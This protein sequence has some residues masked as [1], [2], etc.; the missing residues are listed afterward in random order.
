M[1]LS[2]NLEIS[3]PIESAT[4]LAGES[5]DSVVV[6]HC[7]DKAFIDSLQVLQFL[8][9]CQA[10]AELSFYSSE[11]F[12]DD[13]N[14]FDPVEGY[15][16]CMKRQTALQENNGSKAEK[17][18]SCKMLLEKKEKLKF[19]FQ[20]VYFE[21]PEQYFI[22][23]GVVVGAMVMATIT[24]TV[25]DCFRQ[26]KRNV[27]TI[28]KGTYTSYVLITNKNTFLSVDTFSTAVLIADPVN[29]EEGTSNLQFRTKSLAP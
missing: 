29:K 21:S 1:S 25:W 10:G 24:G 18:P 9:P 13:W 8:P 22:P 28:K 5:L 2:Y 11:P 19:Q 7:D 12:Y 16:K 14:T 4:T 26:K 17:S 6:F 3:D 15:V 27:D 20:W 23:F